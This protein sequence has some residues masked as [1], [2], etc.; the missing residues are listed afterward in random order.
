[1]TPHVCRHQRTYLTHTAR[2]VER[3]IWC[4]R[5]SM[6]A[7]RALLPL[8][9]CRHASGQHA[10]LSLAAAVHI[11]ASSVQL[12]GA[13]LL[14]P[15][16]MCDG[17]PARAHASRAVAQCTVHSAR[18]SNDTLRHSWYVAPV[19]PVKPTQAR[20]SSSF[21]RSPTLTGS[22]S[23]CL[24][25]MITRSS[26]SPCASPGLRGPWDSSCWGGVVTSADVA[27]VPWDVSL[28]FSPCSSPWS[29][30][31]CSSSASCPGRC[32]GV[33]AAGLPM[34][35]MYRPTAGESE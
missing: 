8:D 10:S 20:P 27:E 35:T 28:P 16:P 26:P 1:M 11:Q 30:S 15:Q 17:V 12:Y 29:S 4:N 31:S 6:P 7:T 22:I 32:F 13:R 21:S 19:A 2:A 34:G 3:I 33:T 18:A 9:A 5:D 23:T 14:P 24:P 25:S